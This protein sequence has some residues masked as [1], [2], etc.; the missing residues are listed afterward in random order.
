MICKCFFSKQHVLKWKSPTGHANLMGS[1]VCSQD[2]RGR[3]TWE[4]VGPNPFVTGGKASI[5]FLYGYS[6]FSTL[7]GIDKWWSVDPPSQVEKK[8][9]F[10]LT[11]VVHVLRKETWFVLN[12]MKGGFSFVCHERRCFCRERQFTIL[13][14]KKRKTRVVIFYVSS[15]NTKYK[16]K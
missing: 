14:I 8:I 13:I 12:A 4:S 1:L 2:Y 10:F 15:K 7:F 6:K 9:I 5:N 11:F 16:E 3:R